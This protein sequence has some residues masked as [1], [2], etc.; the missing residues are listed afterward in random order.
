MNT[1]A[2]PLA[3]ASIAV[4]LA[5]PWLDQ[6]LVWCGWTAVAGALLLVR[7]IRGWW[8]EAWTLAGATM[9]L[10]IAFHWTPK[11]MAYAMNVEQ[12]TGL[13]PFAGTD[14]EAGKLG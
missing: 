11:V 2:A 9:A 7:Q 4:L 14:G 5:A 12:A 10:A 13:T 6:Q 1:L 8:G 3:A